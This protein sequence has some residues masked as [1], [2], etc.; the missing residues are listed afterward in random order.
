LA[1]AGLWS[2]WKDPE[3][4]ERIRTCT[5]VTG[6]PNALVT[7]LHDRMPVVL[8]ATSWDLWL[9]PEVRD[10]DLLQS[11]LTTAPAADMIEHAVS[12]LVN[13]VA[14]N[15]P[16]LITPLESGAVDE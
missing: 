14:N 5:I 8:P 12:T 13:K 9:D 11:V 4:E 15:V 2:S 1:L 7:P 3:T 6:E 10:P 16:E